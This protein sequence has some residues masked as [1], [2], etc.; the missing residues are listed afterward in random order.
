VTTAAKKNIIRRLISAAERVR[1]DMTAMKLRTVTTT[2]T[3]FAR[4]SHID[5]EV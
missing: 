3:S 4:L 5:P 2:P 1:D